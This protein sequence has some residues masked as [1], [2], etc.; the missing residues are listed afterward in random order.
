MSSKGWTTAALLAVGATASTRGQAGTWLPRDSVRVAGESEEVG[1]VPPR[2]SRTQG[3]LRLWW[4]VNLES[5]V[6]REPPMLVDVRLK[7]DCRR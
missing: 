2:Y 1:I 4:G 5:R 7:G 6:E 3:D